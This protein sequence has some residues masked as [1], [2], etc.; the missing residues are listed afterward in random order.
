MR[1]ERLRIAVAVDVLVPRFGG[2]LYLNHSASD[3]RIHLIPGSLFPPSRDVKHGQ[4]VKGV[5]TTYA[6]QFMV[7][8]F[9]HGSLSCCSILCFEET[10]SGAHTVGGTLL[11]NVLQVV[12]VVCV[13]AVDQF[14]R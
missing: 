10:R 4:P 13:E 2:C 6:K 5:L 3:K 8:H 12:R 1:V 14:S 9:R 11:S 7:A